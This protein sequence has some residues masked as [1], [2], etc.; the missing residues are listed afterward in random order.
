[1]FSLEPDWQSAVQALLAA[2]VRITALVL[3]QNKCAGDPSKTWSQ[4]PSEAV[5]TN[6]KASKGQKDKHK[7][8]GTIRTTDQGESGDLLISP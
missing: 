7:S 4:L 5:I 3:A 1:M 6:L 8:I 2:A